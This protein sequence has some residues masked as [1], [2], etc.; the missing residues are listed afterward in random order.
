[1]RQGR[2]A[3]NKPQVAR[4]KQQEPV[5]QASVAPTAARPNARPVIHLFIQVANEVSCTRWHRCGRV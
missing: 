2:R 4:L 1:M 3:L 5:I